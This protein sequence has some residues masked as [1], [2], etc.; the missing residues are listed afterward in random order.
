[1][2]STRISATCLIFGVF[3]AGAAQA[4]ESTSPKQNEPETANSGT[5]TRAG[6][7]PGE[8]QE[9]TSEAKKEAAE[10]FGRGLAFYEDGDYGLA[11]I[12]FERAYQLVPD[13]RVLYNIGQVSIQLSRS[14]QALRALEQYL[15]EGGEGLGRERIESVRRDL[16]M[17]EARTAR[18]TIT[19]TEGAQV[20]IDDETYGTLPLEGPLLVD[21]GRHRIELKREGYRDNSERLT[22]AGAE[23]RKIAVEL[24]KRPKA[25]PLVA[26]PTPAETP[27]KAPRVVID[28]PAPPAREGPPWAVIGWSTTGALAGGAILSGIV[29]LNASAKFK[30]LKGEP[31]VARSELD[32]QAQTAQTWLLAADILGAAAIAAGGVSLYLSLGQSDGG[33]AARLSTRRVASPDLE[34]R[35]APRAVVVSQHF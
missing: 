31:D 6:E 3:F 7:V 22:L 28:V 12:E 23:D 5:E 24:Q 27:Q 13:Y 20:L 1:M 2:F 34:L 11:L 32:D 17:L 8:P 29:G 25:V 30:D 16:E 35:F 10:R 14:S 21:A 18:L 4:E 9:P 26:M 19:G 15:K 33:E